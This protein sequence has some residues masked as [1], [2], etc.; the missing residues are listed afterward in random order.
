MSGLLNKKVMMMNQSIDQWVYGWMK[1]MECV[2]MMMSEAGS[3]KSRSCPPSPSS[4]ISETVVGHRAPSS[5]IV[6]HHHQSSSSII[7]I[8]SSFLASTKKRGDIGKALKAKMDVRKNNPHS[9][10]DNMKKK[11]GD[12]L[13][14]LAASLFLQEREMH[15]CG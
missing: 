7:M 1:A 9:Y 6:R 14:F 5:I 4:V 13:A 12:V 11:C 2:C 3:H 15:K 10:V 8:I